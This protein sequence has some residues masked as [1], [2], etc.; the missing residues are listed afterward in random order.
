MHKNQFTS[1]RGI[2]V[3]KFN[4]GKQ[5]CALVTLKKW[6]KIYSIVKKIQIGS[7]ATKLFSLKI[8]CPVTQK[9]RLKSKKVH[10]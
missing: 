6:K 4:I 9:R 7:K 1:R 8:I 10:E 5:Q 3:K 2:F